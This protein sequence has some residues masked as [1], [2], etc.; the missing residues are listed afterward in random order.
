MDREGGTVGA[1]PRGGEGKG[2]VAHKGCKQTP[3]YR[4]QLW[5]TWG[6]AGARDLQL[7][8][9]WLTLGPKPSSST[10]H[11]NAPT[12]S[13]PKRLILRA[14]A[15]RQAVTMAS[16]CPPRQVPLHEFSYST[17]TTE[18]IFEV[19]KHKFGVYGTQG[20]LPDAEFDTGS[21][22]VPNVLTTNWVASSTPFFGE[23]NN[24]VICSP[25][26]CCEGTR[27]FASKC[28][29]IWVTWNSVRPNWVD[30]IFTP[31]PPSANLQV[32]MAGITMGKNISWGQTTPLVCLEKYRP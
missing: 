24:T 19:R 22:V 10:V 12:A 7:R 30:R 17:T 28:V 20:L 8:D 21:L 11:M 16:R 5:E 27:A 3:L 23:S 32:V 18:S 4:M 1:E 13:L 15:F 25:D 14:S 29:F 9:I 31:A 6:K 26:V 2:G